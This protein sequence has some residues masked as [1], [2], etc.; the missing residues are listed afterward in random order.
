MT[1]APVLALEHVNKTVEGVKVIN[2]LGFALKAGET[3]ILFGLNGAGKTTLVSILAGLQEADSGEAVFFGEKC[4]LARSRTLL[5]NDIAFVFEGPYLFPF[6]TVTENII[7]SRLGGTMFFDEEAARALSFEA[8]W[9]INSLG[10]GIDP[11][12]IVSR[13]NLAQQRMTEIARALF[14]KPKIIIMDEPFESLGARERISVMKA[15]DDFKR[16]EGAALITFQRFEHIFDFADRVSVLFDGRIFRLENSSRT[17]VEDIMKVVYGGRAKDP[18][19]KL[20]IRKGKTCMRVSELRVPGKLCEVSFSLRESEILGIYGEVGSGRTTLAQT[21]FGAGGGY[22][23]SITLWNRSAVIRSPSDAI[24]NGIAYIP[25]ERSAK[26]LFGNMNLHA[27]LVSSPLVSSAFVCNPYAEERRLSVYLKKMNIDSRY[28][29][30]EAGALNAGLCQKALILKWIISS[31]RIYI[32]DEPTKSLDIAAKYEFYNIL[33]DLILKRAAV[34]MISSD[35]FELTGMCDRILFMK[36][37]ALRREVSKSAF[38]EIDLGG[39]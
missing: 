1:D 14:Q 19:P 21:I 22:S 30:S 36:E 35:I 5:R 6:A 16:G 27:N 26:G 9:L 31:A 11:D 12:A 13:L 20:D 34:I 33:N 25:D 4:D 10:F 17:R 15:L 28:L 37:G 7:A 3:H 39:A 23:G 32:F 8:R 29:H 38:A 24:N 18:F 2:D